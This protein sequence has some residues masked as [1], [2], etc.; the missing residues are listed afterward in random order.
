MKSLRS[1]LFWT[2]LTAGVLASVVILAM[3][4][5][6]VVL[7]LK[8]QIQD[9]VER[10]VRYVTPRESP[11]LGA[12]QILAAVTAAMPGASPQSLALARDPAAAASVN[13]GRDA[14]V[15][16]D[17]Y[18][19]VVLGSGSAPVARFFQ[20]MTSWHRYMGAS[21]ERRP[22]GRS[23]T[24]VSNLAFLLLAVTGLYIWWPKQLTH[25]HLRPIVW[26]RRS[27]TGRPRDFNWHNTIGFWCL[28]P[29]VIMTISGAVISY[30]WA[31]NLVYRVTGSPVPAARGGT[32]GGAAREI[33]NRASAGRTSAEGRGRPS[34]S[35]AREGA[36]GL[37]GG[38]ERGNRTA[39]RNQP[40][41]PIV[42]ADLDRIWA[43]AERQVPTWSLLSMRL[44]TREGDPV[45]FTITDGA[46][47]NPFARSN[48]TLNGASGEV[49]QWQP[50]ADGSR[51][52]KLRGWLRFAHTGELGGLPGQIVAGIGCLGGVFLVC[53]GLSLAFRRLW[54]WSLWKRLAAG[55][56]VPTR[57]RTS[58]IARES[59]IRRE[60]TH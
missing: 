39:T 1:V 19:G 33:A 5:T 37:R 16:V 35:P 8:P 59:V 36:A 24:G 43:Q 22:I 55:A 34:E 54:N 21:G 7:A 47:W 51:G 30:T 17:P 26:F 48:L 2:H 44:P 32:P 46:H 14:N 4:F 3:S 6:G 11:R 13:I 31:T 10:D 60:T 50:Y 52:Q 56:P 29:I 20:T 9:W 28:I 53:T 27:L 45:A 25:Q 41:V 38:A 42:P 49:I 40:E 12:Q 15:Y 23:A 57:A 58:L 18:T